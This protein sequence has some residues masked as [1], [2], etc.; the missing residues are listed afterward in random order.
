MTAAAVAE[1]RMACR[2]PLEDEIETL[3]KGKERIEV[4]EKLGLELGFSRYIE[5]RRFT[6]RTRIPRGLLLGTILGSNLRLRERKSCWLR[7]EVTIQ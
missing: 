7:C 6:T 3:T 5:T 1:G 4:K 2:R